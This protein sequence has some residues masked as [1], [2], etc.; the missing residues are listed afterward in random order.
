[1]PRQPL[2]VA[3]LER[4]DPSAGAAPAPPSDLR[5]RR[6]PEETPG[7]LGIDRR[8]EEQEHRDPESVQ[9][10]SE[11][12]ADEDD[13]REEHDQGSFRTLEREH[14]RSMAPQRLSSG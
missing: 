6:I 9:G 12:G 10:V 7:R 5:P 2:L 13:Q 8:D 4:D 1:M 14:G 3:R 11:Q